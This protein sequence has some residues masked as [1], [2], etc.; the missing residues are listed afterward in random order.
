MVEPPSQVVTEPFL[1]WRAW[2]LFRGPGGLS[3]V[4][5]NGFSV[6]CP[7]RANI[8]ECYSSEH[9]LHPAYEDSCGLYAFKNAATLRM[10]WGGVTVVGS[11]ALWG[12]VVEHRFGYRAQFA[13]PQRLR[14][15]CGE[16]LK[17]GMAT[18]NECERVVPVT[19][20][21]QLTRSELDPKE[22]ELA[23]ICSLHAESA[24]R[25]DASDLAQEV[26][27]ELLST[28]AVDVLN[29]VVLPPVRMPRRHPRRATTLRWLNTKLPSRK[30]SQS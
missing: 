28:Y 18:V 23:A 10:L 27:S 24:T 13:Y 15:I 6:W 30:P 17:L 3:L 29:T 1:G 25:D 12:R 7:L 16:C 26:Q 20:D 21:R 19:T 9:D 4:S 14:L 11:V 2:R 22:Q 8:A 5:V